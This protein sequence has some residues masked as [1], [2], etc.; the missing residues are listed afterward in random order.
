MGGLQTLAAISDYLSAQL[1]PTPSLP[2]SPSPTFTV[3]PS[4]A[5]SVSPPLSPSVTPSA[6]LPVRRHVLRAVPA[7][8]PGFAPA[9]LH[10]AKKLVIT[11]D[12]RGVAPALAEALADAGVTATVVTEVPA[13]ADAL[14][15]LD[16]LKLCATAAES[17]AAHQTAFALART[18]APRFTAQG[19]L[20][21]T[22]Q[23]TGGAFGLSGS[24]PNAWQ[25][26]YAGLAKTAAKEWPRAVVRALDLD[27]PAKA[28]P[29]KLAARLTAELLYGGD[30]LEIGLGPK[31]ERTRLTV[32][33]TSLAPTTAPRLT[34]ASVIVATGGARGV[35]A[36][37]LIALA[38]AHQPR[39]ALLGR[40]ALTEE[41]AECRALTRPEEIQSALLARAKSSGRAPSPKELTAAVRDFLAQREIRA[42]LAALHAAGS[43]ADYFTCDA[44]NVADVDRTLA[45]VRE[46]FGPITA[47]VHGAGVL[48]DRLIAE[49][50]P[51]QF[52]RVFETKVIGL[53]ALLTATAGDPLDTIILFSSVAG[54]FGNRGQS[55]YAMA[56]EVLNKVAQAEASRRGDTCLVRS[57]NWGPWD[58]GMVTP[59]LRAH[60]LAQG[61]GLIPHVGGAAAFVAEF[62]G[63]SASEVEVVIGSGRIDLS[64]ADADQPTRRVEIRVTSQRYPFLAD[65]V[66]KDKAVV[67]LALVTEW[68]LRAAELT[69]PTLTVSALRD[70]QVVKAVLF[71]DLTRDQHLLTLETR[72][73]A[74]GSVALRISDAAT[75]QLQ[76]T[77]TAI[78]SDAPHSAR[79]SVPTPNG[80]TWRP[81]GFESAGAYEGR[82][83]HG[84][85]F[86]VITGLHGLSSQAARLTLE[87]RDLARPYGADWRVGPALIDGALQ[88][89]ALWTLEAHGK[90]ALPLR[91]AELAFL[92]PINAS[93]SVDCRLHGRDKAGL[94]T[95]SDIDCVDAAGASVVTLRGVEC[96]HV[97][98]YWTNGAA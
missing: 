22:V 97:D 62:S 63:A 25:G 40:T 33:E 87:N 7:K 29:K 59:Q 46:V 75:R 45:R 85:Q 88:S 54:R 11:D 48:A 39:I 49:K 91:I 26:G 10:S 53:E 47:L 77:A 1:A 3:S 69:R 16:G 9:G 6:D 35:T 60:F 21:V 12:G 84:P 28:T 67:P 23:A 79:A 81:F 44:Q 90:S 30:E 42:T 14:I 64:A 94:G 15:L 31:S 83:F 20:F 68:M 19:G 86:Q 50:T 8:A 32:V 13:D 93:E 92:R 66:V 78:Y 89:A 17:S 52:T 18:V 43:K 57:I 36:S 72:E 41:P 34:S 96:F 56:N 2:V 73:Q 65:H 82:L 74:D 24:T 80:E 98:S 71:A 38:S 5:P 61:I 37:S 51:E 27:T 95:V 70:I 4:S 55:D 58:G 76:F